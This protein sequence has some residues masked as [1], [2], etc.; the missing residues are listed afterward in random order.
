MLKYGPKSWK[1]TIYALDDLHLPVLA[2]IACQKLEV[3]VKVDEIASPERSPVYMKRTHPEVFA[4][5][6]CIP[7]EYEIKLPEGSRI[8]TPLL[9]RVLGE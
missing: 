3:I 6:G 1:A 9:P 4:G 5:Q 7:E 8:P 2:R